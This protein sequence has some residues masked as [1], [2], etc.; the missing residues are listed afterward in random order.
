MIEHSANC[1]VYAYSIVVSVHH[2][3]ILMSY[4]MLLTLDLYVPSFQSS[5]TVSSL[6]LSIIP[7]FVENMIL[8]ASHTLTSKQRRESQSL[9]NLILRDL[10][11]TAFRL[12][13]DE[14]SDL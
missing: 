13:D 5:L 9:R 12:S 3:Q 7:W 11:I 6:S 4:L 14:F 2:I 1:Q 8:V 10:L